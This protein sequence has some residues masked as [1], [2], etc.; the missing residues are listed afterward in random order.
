MKIT[1]QIKKNKFGRWPYVR[2]EEGKPMTFT[3]FKKASDHA[4]SIGAKM[5]RSRRID[6]IRPRLR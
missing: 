1:L 4:A 6:R 3:S 5:Y 2:D